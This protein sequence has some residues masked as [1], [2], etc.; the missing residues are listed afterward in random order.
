LLQ[1]R[2]GYSF[3]QPDLLRQ[4]LTHKSF[5]NEQVGMQP[6]YNE[7]LEFLGDSVLGLAVSSRIYHEMPEL[8]EGQLTRIRAEVV[9]ERSLSAIGRELGLGDCLLLGRGEERSGGRERPSLLANAVE[10]LLGAIMCDGGFEPARSVA[11]A[12]FGAAIGRSLRDDAGS[13]HKTRLQELLQARQGRPPVYRLVSAEG[14]EHQRLYRIEV[15]VDEQTIGVGEG[16]SKKA[17][18]QQAAK[19]ALARLA[20]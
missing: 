10:A 8:A 19:A 9:N 7:R 15:R 16:R 18:E 11:E 6:Q 17:A 2:L 14:P 1:Q 13:D 4:A 20:G 3:R 5:S 12:L